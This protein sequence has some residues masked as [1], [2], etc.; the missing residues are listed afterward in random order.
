MKK[1]EKNNGITMIALAVTIIVLLI[2]A[3]VT[4]STFVG[5]NGIYNNAN[6]TKK[7]SAIVEEK[8]VLN[9]S[10]AAA[11]GSNPKAKVEEAY[12]R[13]YLNQNVG[14]ENEKYTLTT[15]GKNFKVTFTETGNEYVISKDGK[16]LS[17]DEF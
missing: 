8:E 14:N 10:I 12:L 7:S 11:V 17:N 13:K 4:I 16:V 9:T 1:N 6:K 15:D 2:L 3:G 5:G